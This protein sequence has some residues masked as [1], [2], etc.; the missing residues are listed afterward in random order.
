MTR[1]MIVMALLTLAAAE[2]VSGQ[3]AAFSGHA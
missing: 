2:A 1:H 3:F